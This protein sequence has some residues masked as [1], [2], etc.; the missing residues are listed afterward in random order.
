MQSRTLILALSLLFAVGATAQSQTSYST[1]NESQNNAPGVRIGIGVSPFTYIGP[2]VLYGTVEEQ[3]NVTK[4][5]L[6]V[7][8]SLSFPIVRDR[9]YL[10]GQA[11]LLNIG[12]D[13]S[14]DVGPGQNPFL[15]NEIFLGEGDL[16]LN[17]MSYNRSSVVPYIF[18]GF[19]A[20][21]ADPFG[22]DDTIEAQDQQRTAYFIPAGLGVDF[23]LTRNV[24]F[25]LEGSYRFVLNEIGEALD[26]P[27]AT[28]LGGQDPCE[29]DPE[30]MECK[31]KKFPELPECKEEDDPEVDPVDEVNFD[32][33]FNSALFTGGILFGFGSA[34]APPPPPAPP[35]TPPAPPPPPPTPPPPPPPSPPTVCDL[36]ELNAVYFEYG[37][38]DLSPRTL[39]LLE[40]NVQLLREHPECCLFVDGYTDSSEYDEFGM[41]LAGSRA[42]SVYDFYIDRGITADR[43][44]IRNRGA[45]VPPCDK[46]DPEEGCRRG[47]RVES[48]PMDCERFNEMIRN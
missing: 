38:T 4:T 12:A 42:Q 16:L 33:R 44:Q 2:N 30:S 46:E 18:S 47:R 8:G 34:P 40:E 41:P 43:M 29:K 45:S 24:S 27:V 9:V 17:L 26:M 28:V 21:V 19:G 3:E 48:I 7:T 37:E 1:L 36:V 35:P 39:A 10:R 22:Q 5:R 31:C 15:T 32:T 13:V 20:L 11:G 23:Q 6:G 14:D 25:Y